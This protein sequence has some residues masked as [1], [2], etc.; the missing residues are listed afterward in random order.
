MIKGVHGYG[1]YVWLNRDSIRADKV[2][3]YRYMRG[4]Q[5]LLAM[6]GG[7]SLPK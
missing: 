4:W 5:F 2:K 7:V 3:L 6:N 1:R